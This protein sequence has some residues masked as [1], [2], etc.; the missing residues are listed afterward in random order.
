MSDPIRLDLPFPPS[1]NNL[2][3]QSRT[4]RRFPSKKYV[5]WRRAADWLIRSSERLRIATL[6]G[7]FHSEPVSIKIYLVAG[8]NRPRDADNYSKGIIDSLVRCG[9][10]PDDSAKH[11]GDIHVSW[12][13]VN[14]KEPKAIVVITDG[15]GAGVP[16]G[17]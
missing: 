4:G 8:D 13:P 3:S 16:L 2:F 12:L 5:A 10:L 6:N 1:V 11:I 17:A 15:R 14:K 7:S 9:V